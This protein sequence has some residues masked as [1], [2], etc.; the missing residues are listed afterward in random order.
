[1]ITVILPHSAGGKV[2]GKGAV[3]QS[4]PVELRDEKLYLRT[5]PT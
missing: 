5:N 4:K 2:I 3:S 1:V